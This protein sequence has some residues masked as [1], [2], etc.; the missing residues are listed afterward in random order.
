MTAILAALLVLCAGAL[1]GLAGWR[2]MGR[3]G[4]AGHR[5]VALRVTGFGMTRSGL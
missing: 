3:S 5:P 4:A 1:R 2:L